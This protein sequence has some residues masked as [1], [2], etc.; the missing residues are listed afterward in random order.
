MECQASIKNESRKHLAKFIYVKI[1]KDYFVRDMVKIIL[2][3]SE[4]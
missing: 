2:Y 3:V 1:K 4:Q